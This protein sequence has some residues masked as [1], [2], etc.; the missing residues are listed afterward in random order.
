MAQLLYTRSGRPS[1]ARR[2]DAN[3]NAFGFLRLALA[4][5]VLVA[6]AWPLGLARQSFGAS[7][8]HGQTDL[9]TL[10]VQGFF[11]ISGFLVA[12]SALR[13]SPG[14]FAWHR[15]LRTLP[16]LWVCLLVTALV[17]APLVY[18]Y[19]QRTLTGFWTHPDGPLRYVA[20][21]WFASMEQYPISGLLADT[22]FGRLQGGP[23]AFDGSLWSLRYEFACY[24]FVWLL[25]ACAVLR[26]ARRLVLALAAGAYL[27]VLFDLAT[28]AAWTDRPPLRGAIG[29]LPLVGSF[30]YGWALYLGFLFLLGACARLY[31]H[32]LPMTAVGAAVAGAVMLASMLLGGF[33]AF[34]LPAYAYLVLYLATALPRP[35]RRIGRRRDYSYGVYIYAFPVQQMLALVGGASHGLTVYILLSLLGTLLFA[36]PSWHL[37]EGPALRLRGWPGPALRLRGWPGPARRRPHN[38][39]GPDGPAGTAANP[40]IPAATH[41]GG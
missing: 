10:S 3:D 4:T 5:G 35:L 28:V 40:P 38:R 30:A 8:T 33:F 17:L 25:A 1:L 2:Y 7:L 19:E 11:V 29:P 32:R 36:V 21:N 39:V 12:G 23:S 9:G 27:L 34:G 13:L 22:P 15:A 14:R 18:W 20:V 26:R 37:L 41:S 6:H 24:A 16:G 31:A